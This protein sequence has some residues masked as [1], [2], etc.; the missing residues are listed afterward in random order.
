[1]GAGREK[2]ALLRMEEVEFIVGEGVSSE[3]CRRGKRKGK[4][5]ACCFFYLSAVAA[6]KNDMF[7]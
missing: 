7:H 2:G 3:Y 5:G 4:K 1:M 6:G